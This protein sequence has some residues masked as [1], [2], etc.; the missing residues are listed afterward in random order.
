MCCA[1]LAAASHIKSLP[2]LLIAWRGPH[3]V[4]TLQ[5][6]GLWSTLCDLLKAQLSNN[7]FLRT[8]YGLIVHIP[9]KWLSCKLKIL[10]LLRI[11]SFLLGILPKACCS[12]F[13]KTYSNDS[14]TLQYWSDSHNP[15][16][17]VSH[18]WLSQ[19]LRFYVDT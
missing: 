18:L 2:H 10:I 13:G 4:I 6:L 1:M 17:T 7:A 12:P 15:A 19:I 3:W 16:D 5:Y 9:R 11:C 8:M 14:T